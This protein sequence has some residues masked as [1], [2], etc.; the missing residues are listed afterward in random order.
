MVRKE[1]VDELVRNSF[2]KKIT[3]FEMFTNKNGEELQITEMNLPEKAFAWKSINVSPVES[4]LVLRN[5][6]RKGQNSEYRINIWDVS[7]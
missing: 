4:R 3:L 6:Q 1:V 7:P 2:A 5:G